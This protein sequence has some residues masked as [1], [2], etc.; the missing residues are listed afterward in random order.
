LSGRRHLKLSS[1]SMIF[2]PFLRPGAG[3]NW[4]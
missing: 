4:S 3:A 2:F 1:E